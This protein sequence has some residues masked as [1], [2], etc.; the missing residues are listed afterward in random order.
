MD[1][2]QSGASRTGLL[3]HKS[4]FP[5]SGERLY[6]E[7]GG[8]EDGTNIQSYIKR[9]GDQADKQIWKLER[10]QEAPNKFTS[11]MRDE[12]VRSWKAQYYKKS[13]NNAG[14]TLSDAERFQPMA[15]RRNV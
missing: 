12:I 3:L 6:L 11:V 13:Q 8:G 9:T 14:Y 2:N 4:F 15:G 10:V 1:N 7:I 5:A